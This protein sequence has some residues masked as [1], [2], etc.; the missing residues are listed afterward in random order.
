MVMRGHVPELVKVKM[1][2]DGISQKYF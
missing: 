2:P 1:N